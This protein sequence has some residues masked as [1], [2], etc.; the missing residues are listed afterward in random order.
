MIGRR[1][2][3]IVLGVLACVPGILGAQIVSGLGDLPSDQQARP[4]LNEDAE[5][6][7]G[8][9]WRRG[10]Y[11]PVAPRGAGAA[12]GTSA[13]AADEIRPFGAD[14]F[15][16]GFRGMRSAGLNHAYRI[17]PGDQIT[18]RAWG[19]LDLNRVLPVDAQGNIFIPAV[20]PVQVMGVS[21]GDLDERVRAAIRQVFTDNVSVY[22]NL[23]GVQPVAVYVTGFVESP[24][25][26]AGT[27]D[28]SVL[29]FIDQASGISP[30]GGSF[31]DIRVLRD[32]QPIAQIDLYAFLLHGRL[33]RTQFE[34][35]DT[36]VVGRRG[37]AVTVTGDV[38]SPYRYEV[39][40]NAVRG[41]ELM[42]LV[43]LAPGVSHALLQGTRDGMPYSAYLSLD[44]F[45]ADYLRDGDEVVFAIDT[46]ADTIVVQLEGSFDG[47]SRFAIPRD[48]TLRDLLDSIPVNPQLADVQSVSIRRESVA[49]RQRQSLDDSLRR[50]ET[51]YLG[52]PSATAEEAR[53]RA[54]E[55]QLIS[56]FVQ[57]ARQVEPSGRVVIAHNGHISDLRLQNNDVITIPE[58]SH[59]L[60][61]S[62]EVLVP[63]AMVILEGQ[64]AEDYIRRAGG[65]TERAD[66]RRILVVR[67]NG[68]V[69]PARDAQ[70][71][72]GDEI[73]VLPAVPSKNLQL[74]STI[75]QILYQI[76]ITSRVVLD[77]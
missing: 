74:A 5:P 15:K 24:G 39:P 42:D 47:P 37:P 1:Y 2:A 50:L 4:I 21:N 30:H 27:P 54:V 20:G 56:D 65:F 34:D 36:I 68:E 10:T 57:R 33:P 16:G 18:V 67:Q 31:R 43:Q 48:A 62:G 49:E 40:E 9:D 46:R 73:L 77:I 66:K 72:P 22:T 19:A 44:E 23:Q 35:G 61:V 71:R 32:G 14:L 51:T 52:A 53:I 58:R 63:Q 60:L 12:S 69:V 29:Y 59:S 7:S 45:R 25:R 38:V 26:Y 70:L 8:V 17:L 3:A 13:M 64:R 28:D 75:A 11:G 55:A 6:R 76:A 41:V